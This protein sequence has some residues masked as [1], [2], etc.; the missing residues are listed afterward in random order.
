VKTPQEDLEAES[1]CKSDWHTKGE[2]GKGA[3]SSHPRRECYG[4]C[5]LWPTHWQQALVGPSLHPDQPTSTVIHSPRDA[6]CPSASNGDLRI[7]VQPAR[8]HSRML[9]AHLEPFLRRDQQQPAAVGAGRWCR[10]T[11][12][13]ASAW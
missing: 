5:V 8:T 4:T 12:A 7:P 3:A 1:D 10:E 11:A 6:V 13:A 9:F 2:R